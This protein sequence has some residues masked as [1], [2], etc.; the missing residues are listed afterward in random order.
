[1]GFG[2]VVGILSG[3]ALYLFTDLSSGICFI[4]GLVMWVLGFLASVAT[5]TQQDRKAMR[6]LLRRFENS[7]R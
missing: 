7:D 3:F 6:R 2:F 5:D 1:M 4:F